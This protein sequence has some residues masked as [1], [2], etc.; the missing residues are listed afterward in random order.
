MGT[1]PIFESDFD[2]LTVFNR[3]I[4]ERNRENKRMPPKR[5]ASAGTA[6]AHLAKVLTSPELNSIKNQKVQQKLEAALSKGSKITSPVAAV[7]AADHGDDQLKV[8]IQKLEAELDARNHEFEKKQ[9]EFNAQLQQNGELNELTQKENS[10]MKIE[11]DTLRLQVAQIN[12]SAL[13]KDGDVNMLKVEKE[14]MNAEKSGL[15]LL[16]KQKNAEIES[17]TASYDELATQLKQLTQVRNRY[18]IKLDDLETERKTAEFDVARLRNQCDKYRD[19][20]QRA[21]TESDAK[22]E[23]L[24][25]LRSQLAEERRRKSFDVEEARKDNAALQKRIDMLENDLEEKCNHFQQIQ[26]QSE[27]MTKEFADIDQNQRNEIISQGRLIDLLKGQLDGQRQQHDDQK[28]QVE[29]TKTSMDSL[30]IENTELKNKLIR[31]EKII[32]ETELEKKKMSKELEDANELLNSVKTKGPQLSQEE[33]EGFS[34]TAAAAVKLLKSGM[35]MTEM[36]SEYIE[37]SNEAERLSAE[38]ER[39]NECMDEMVADIREKVP[40]LEKQRKDYENA[41][42]V[43]QELTEQLDETMAEL[44]CLK[45]ELFHAN[46]SRTRLA[47]ENDTFTIQIKTLNKQV[48]ILL[49][50]EVTTSMSKDEAA[51]FY[52][53]TIEMQ[54]TATKYQAENKVLVVRIEQLEADGKE[55]FE[56][57]LKEMS[58]LLELEKL[59]RSNIE[60]ELTGFKEQRRTWSAYFERQKEVENTD[61]T[62]EEMETMVQTSQ[63]SSH[64]KSPRKSLS[65]SEDRIKLGLLEQQMDELKE[66]NA[67]R[68]EEYKEQL[69]DM[70]KTSTASN[71][72]TM[73]LQ[74]EM[75]TLH[76][77]VTMK[78]ESI[79]RLKEDIAL[80]LDKNN[81]LMSTIDIEAKNTGKLTEQYMNMREEN[82]SLQI[83]LKSSKK[84]SAMFEKE[85]EQTQQDQ[86]RA[87][88]H[89]SGQQLILDTIQQLKQ[90]MD[91]K[92]V[93]ETVALKIELDQAKKEALSTKAAADE[94]IKAGV[95]MKARVD[96]QI[97][98]MNKTLAEEQ[99]KTATAT[100]ELQRVKS[101]QILGGDAEQKSSTVQG[102]AKAVATLETKQL[103]DEIR[104]LKAE[105]AK[106]ESQM[107]ELKR[108]AQDAEKRM[109]TANEDYAKSNLVRDKEL[110]ELQKTIEQCDDTVN[111]LEENVTQL[112]S[113]CG[114]E[115]INQLRL[116][117][118]N[119]QCE[120][121][122]VIIQLKERQGELD[123][124]REQYHQQIVQHGKAQ[125]ACST[126]RSENGALKIEMTKLATSSE[127]QK[128]RNDSMRKEWEDE[129][130]ALMKNSEHVEQRMEQQTSQNKLLHD[131]LQTLNEQ[132]R[133]SRRRASMS[134]TSVSFEQSQ[135][136]VDDTDEKTYH[137]ILAIQRRELALVET[138][139]DVDRAE[140]LRLKQRIKNLDR[141][142]EETDSLLRDLEG[143][144]SRPSITS[145]QHAELM[146]KVNQMNILRESN[147]VLR[148]EKMRAV[149][150]RDNGI[151]RIKD[152]EL[153][154]EPL[155]RRENEFKQEQ[156][157]NETE[158]KKQLEEQTKAKTVAEEEVKKLK[159]TTVPSDQ[160][161][162]IISVRDEFKQKFDAK[163]A[164]T[165]QKEAELTDIRIKCDAAQKKVTELTEQTAKLTE[166]DKK[167]EEDA[168]KEK[169]KFRRLQQLAKG[170]RKQVADKTEEIEKTKQEMESKLSDQQNKDDLEVDAEQS[171]KEESDLAKKMLQNQITKLKQD[172]ASAK[173]EL[174]S[175]KKELTECQA[176][177][178]K[179]QE[180]HKTVQDKKNKIVANAGKKIKKLKTDLAE[181]NGKLCTRTR[182]PSSS[183]N[184]FLDGVMLPKHAP[185]T[186]FN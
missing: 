97:D 29:A 32:N 175:S 51:N 131:Q 7:A 46:H 63:N 54:E 23:M 91:E 159:A 122:G 76:M 5:R 148:D 105:K 180:E 115:D 118:E 60:A 83:A 80:H 96:A 171:K 36:F 16:L 43:Q 62:D 155:V 71:C 69:C 77:N 165:R 133:S 162:K 93:A 57:K 121:E 67:E 174:E 161:K 144:K 181:A 81:R 6:H 14:R 40:M 61:D 109:N 26:C 104:T 48:A 139:R 74:S 163:S 166:K 4:E 111:K 52:R 135:T 173:T 103:N 172:L 110:A 183:G 127:V 132:V 85:L 143:L 55:D 65:N 170:Y 38:N 17:L 59:E 125:E 154:L 134:N 114:Q 87:T 15:D 128:A 95:E 160:V 10:A 136:A 25:E 37:K 101:R 129:R 21:V 79:K 33:L 64:K 73:K 130:D 56:A 98:L 182:K 146:E 53:N 102:S 107:A 140:N 88:Q 42:Q 24:R 156:T 31:Y 141:Q 1:H 89:E 22:E 99:A 68:I 153:K 112:K 157:K 82:V 58:H 178:A 84:R 108:I 168:A 45:R 8:K 152:L 34:P 138:S 19:E 78:E 126:L 169:D 179:L 120:L 20:M 44:Q 66:S 117:L 39:L 47:R 158:H 176:E 145:E 49:G 11:I 41:H 35:T 13:N 142:K 18:K 3:V 113:A 90:Q 149:D 12:S 151:K 186:C 177:L 106:I 137:D 123:Q 184:T 94:Q 164:E 147:S 28:A 124:S 150:E 75:K 100:N 9:A 185:E 27:E 116:K 167:N 86:Q 119:A 50:N 72:E 2:C 92:A 70:T 30:V